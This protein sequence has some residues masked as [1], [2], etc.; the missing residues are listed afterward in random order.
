MRRRTQRGRQQLQLLEAATNDSYGAEV[1]ACGVMWKRR[2]SRRGAGKRGHEGQRVLQPEVQALPGQRVRRMR[3]VAHKHHGAV[4]HAAGL[5][6]LQRNSNGFTL[7]ARHK[8]RQH[9]CAFV[10]LAKRCVYVR[11]QLSGGQQRLN[12]REGGR[13][14]RAAMRHL[15]PFAPPAA[16]GASTRERHSPR[17]A[18]AWR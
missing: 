1:G 9:R 16:R 2:A 7:D 3:R 12:K 13:A 5:H 10:T 11:R 14:A 8:R 15:L 4:L 17:P 18:A 6:Q